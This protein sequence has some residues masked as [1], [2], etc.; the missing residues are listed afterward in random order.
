M[1][2]Q[3]NRQVVS[4]AAPKD[5]IAELWKLLGW[6]HG[7]IHG[8]QRTAA[9]TV[10]FSCRAPL[11]HP[12]LSLRTLEAFGLMSTT[13]PLAERKKVSVRA[14]RAGPKITLVIG[15][16]LQPLAWK[17]REWRPKSAQ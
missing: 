15:R 9:K 7:R 3:S 16:V 1:G 11:V 13:V 8:G 4:G 14:H 6:E 5:K 12:W 10:V 2:D 17:H